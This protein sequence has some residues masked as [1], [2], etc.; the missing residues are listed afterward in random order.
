MT[1]RLRTLSVTAL[2]SIGLHAQVTVDWNV[3]ETGFSIA[4]DQQNSL[5]TVFSTQGAGTDI[6]LTKRS[7]SGSLLWSTFFDQTSTTLHDRAT[8]VATDPQGNAIV[9]G[10]VYGGS[11]QNPVA[12]NSIAM[13]F[14]PS[15][16][17]LWRQVYGNFFDGSYTRKCVVDK[18]GFAYVLGLGQS[19][20][21]LVTTVR[22]FDPNGA[23]VWN[24]FDTGIG[25]PINIKFTPDSA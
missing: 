12:A 4:L 10:T 17:L 7:S 16:Q 1:M 2:I 24:W 19:G 22:K 18:A 25:G 21:G 20:N 5:Y 13:K 9:T 8:W 6:I 23:T 15:G 3:P 14:S 11:S